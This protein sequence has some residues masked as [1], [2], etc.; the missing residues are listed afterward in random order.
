MLKDTHTYA[1]D[2][3]VIIKSFEASPL[4]PVKI[5]ASSKWDLI[6]SPKITT[7]GKLQTG[8]SLLSIN[9]YLA[10][11]LFH[12]SVNMQ[13]GLESYQINEALNNFSYHLF[14]LNIKPP[15]VVAYK[16]RLG[17]KLVDTLPGI[18]S[19]DFNKANPSGYNQN[20]SYKIL[21]GNI[22][23]IDFRSMSGGLKKFKSFLDTCFVSLKNN[24]ANGLIVDLRYNGGGNSD[25]GELL[26]SYLTDK[27][28]R[29]SSGRYFKVSLQYQEFMKKNY[30]DQ[31]SKDVTDY[32]KS[33]PGR[34]LFYKYKEKKYLVDNPNRYKLNTY[35]LIGP[36]NL[37]S[38]TMLADGAQTYKIATL[39]GEPTGA[40]ANDGGESYN[41]QLPYSH[42]NIYTSSTYDIRAN[43]KVT[44]EI[45][46][47][48][49][50]LCAKSTIKQQMPYL[51][52][53]LFS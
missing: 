22:G 18:S 9:G 14:L 7:Q 31:L 38:A 11:T 49:T 2:Y 13:G 20:Y 21:E 51:I 33:K 43:G 6:I 40:P 26:L 39:I 36:Q 5:K 1:D 50:S 47:F 41:F 53:L 45:Q 32:L 12:R 44:T 30:P 34:V 29:L 25:Y 37:S 8:D 3:D 19:S 52:R 24:K 48:Q 4:F 27:P 17:Q 46:F 42:F 15:F 23:Y 10:G 35:F 28:Y 16:N